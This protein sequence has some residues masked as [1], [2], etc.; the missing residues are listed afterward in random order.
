MSRIAPATCIII[1][2]Y[3]F[4]A[5]GQQA[6][7]DHFELDLREATNAAIQFINALDEALDVTFVDFNSSIRI[8]RFEPQAIHICSSECAIRARR[9]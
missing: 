9:A 2:R 3:N 7:I 4:K 6:L 8:G 5:P 1:E